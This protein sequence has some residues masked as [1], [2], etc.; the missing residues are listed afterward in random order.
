MAPLYSLDMSSTNKI[1]APMFIMLSGLPCTGKSTWCMHM[2]DA[3]N[4]RHIPVSILSADEMALQ[5][6]EEH[7]SKKSNQDKILTYTTVC[8]T[9]RM[10][11]EERY[12]AAVHMTCH[13]HSGIVILDRT[14]LASRWRTEVLNVIGAKW[15]HAITFDVTN[16]ANWRKNLKHRNIINPEKNI[17]NKVI[18]SLMRYASPPTTDEGLTSIT[19]CVALGEPGWEHKFQQ[20]I[21]KLIN[22]Y[23]LSNE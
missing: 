16:T 13:Q 22:I 9:H 20:T 15:V 4:M 10:Q 12:K 7:N 1:T 5:M 18:A 3:L 2:L 6:C 8:T 19:P 11:L 14:Y 23:V 17:T 21:T